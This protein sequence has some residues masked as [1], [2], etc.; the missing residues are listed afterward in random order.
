M[1][2]IVLR[3]LARWPNVPDCYGWLALDRRGEWL[4]GPE[5]ERIAHRGLSEFISRNYVA[6]TQ[7]RWYFQNGP[8]R[9]WVGLDY[10]PWVY[11]VAPSS[12]RL[13][14]HT[15]ASVQRIDRV[16]LD[17]N[18]TLGMLSEHGA[19]NVDDRDLLHLAEHLRDAQGGSYSGD[20]NEGDLQLQLGA[21]GVSLGVERIDAAALPR[22][23]G[24][25]RDPQP[26]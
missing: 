11:R 5:R 23:F 8:Q 25:V 18:G 16:W 6:D 13:E 26:A 3:A 9:V 4:M 1:D 24:F 12:E 10:T 17:E 15:G 22:C 20:V 19:G 2:D 14:T 21:Y 7:G